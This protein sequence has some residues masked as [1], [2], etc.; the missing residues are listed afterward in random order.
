MPVDKN[1][2]MKQLK[3]RIEY[4]EQKRKWYPKSW[5]CVNKKLLEAY[6]KEFN[7]RKKHGETVD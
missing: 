7:Y 3:L 5:S 2:S 1:L 4:L 6:L